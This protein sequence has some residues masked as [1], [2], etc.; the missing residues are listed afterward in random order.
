M[1]AA[2]MDMEMPSQSAIV[3]KR[4]AMIL[5]Q[6]LL[7]VLLIALW[8]QASSAGWWDPFFFGYPTKVWD[9]LVNW[10]NTGTLWDAVSITAQLLAIGF[11][12]GLA[13]GVVIGVLLA[14]SRLF[15][16]VMEPFIVFFN[17]IPRIVLYPFLVVWFG[18]G[19][20][21][22]VISIILVMTPTVAIN[23]AAGFR[24][25]QGEYLDNLRAQGASGFDV[26]RQ[27]Y[28][29]SLALWLLTTCRVTFSFAFQ[30]AI[31]AQL[32]VSTKG[33][34]YLV[35]EGKDNYD[36]NAIYG[37][38]AIVVVMAVAFD[39]ALSLIERRAT[40]WMPSH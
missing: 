22:Q 2:V 19:L 34:G 27:V 5:G 37:A 17:A 26:A 12:S 35:T 13:I 15:R 32:L 18:F 28:V 40:R 24:E 9:Q 4:A 33:V 31:V 23:V 10:A 30:A 11:L 8:D 1:A 36:V 14:T 29:P 3:A 16:D 21:P 20:L 39:L 6:I 38:M 7:V 25:V